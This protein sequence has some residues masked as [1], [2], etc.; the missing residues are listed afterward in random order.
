MLEVQ[1]NTPTRLVIK[2]THGLNVSTLI[3][4]KSTGR[5]RFE[6]AVLFWKR[7][8]LDVAL[9]DISRSPSP[10]RGRAAAKVTFPWCSSS[11][12]G[13][14]EL[15]DAV[16]EAEAVEAVGQMQHVSG[17]RHRAK[18]VRRPNPACRP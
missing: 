3:L 4:D 7:K 16:D 1:E 6:R 8:P 13:N 15:A 2:L 9:D 12:A 10:R 14:S 11:P 17:D 5:A 18:P